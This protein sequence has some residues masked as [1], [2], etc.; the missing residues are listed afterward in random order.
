M[1]VS[2]DDNSLP[3]PRLCAH[4]G[5]N[6]VA[7]ENSMPAFGAAVALG[8]SEIEFDIWATKDRQLVSIHDPTLDRV[9]NG[10]GSVWEYTYDELLRFD[11]GIKKDERFKGLRIVRFEEILERFARQ[12]IMNIHVKI[13]DMEFEDN[14]LREIISLI[15]KFVCEKHIYLMTKSDNMLK[16][17][18]KTYPEINI[19]VGHDKNLPFEIVDRAIE[20]G[21]HKVQFHKTHFNKE[22]IDKAHENGIHCNIFWSDDPDEAKYLLNMGIDTI[23]TNDYQRISFATG[24]K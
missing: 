16:A 8:A 9:S 21:A 20:I 2:L 19:C 4:R 17:V 10:S 3:Y 5:F 12:V 14:M 22:L 1:F 13:W 18:K 24:L 15:E 6:S 11:F 7:P 23:L